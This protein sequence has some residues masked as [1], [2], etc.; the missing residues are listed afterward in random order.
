MGPQNNCAYLLLKTEQ[1]LK[2]LCIEIIDN[3]LLANIEK[4]LKP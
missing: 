3:F 2:C 1:K 4:P